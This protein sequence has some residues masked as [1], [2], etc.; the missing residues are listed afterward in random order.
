M[1]GNREGGKQAAETNKE[2]YGE[3]F[4]R[5]IG[6]VGGKK[7]TTGGFYVNR[8]LASTAGRKGGLKRRRKGIK[9]REGKRGR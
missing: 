7:G 3:D 2:L 8:E 5:K 1:S 4:Y 9:N 6:S